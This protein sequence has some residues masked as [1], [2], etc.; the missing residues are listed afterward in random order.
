MATLK[1][2]PPATTS[3][4]RY[5]AKMALFLLLN[6][7]TALAVVT[8]ASVALPLRFHAAT[9][10]L[11]RSHVRLVEGAYVAFLLLLTSV[12]LPGSSLVVTGDWATMSKADKQVVISNHQIYPDW[13]YLFIL[14]WSRG[15]HNDV[16]VI[17]IHI[18]SRLPLFGQGMWFFEFIFMKQRFEKDKETMARNLTAAKNNSLPLWLL[19]FPEGT[20]NTPGNIEKS[21]SF[22]KK[23]NINSHPNHCILPKVTGLHFSL[24]QLSPAVKHLYDLTVGYSGLTPDQIPYDEYLIDKCFFSGIYPREIHI[25]IKKYD[26]NTL[27]GFR[28]IEEGTEDEKKSRFEAWLRGLWFDKDERLAGFY[29]N[30]DMVTAAAAAS[31]NAVEDKKVVIPISPKPMDVVVVAALWVFGFTMCKVYLGAIFAGA[32]ALVNLIWG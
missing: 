2:P 27:P 5:Y 19:I 32:G 9:H 4:P 26:V 28:P 14:A 10:A 3:A 1:T 18:L 11:Y 12:F 15:C 24:Q 16:R 13:F 29:R 20:L 6:V 8:T 7:L 25:H 21:K 31:G 23:M 30:G 17:L 22:A